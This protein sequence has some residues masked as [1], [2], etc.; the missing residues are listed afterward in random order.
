[1]ELFLDTGPS[2]PMGD[3][4]IARSLDTG[5][6]VSGGLRT[7]FFNPAETAA[8]NV[9]LGLNFMWN[10]GA[11]NE[12]QTRFPCVVNNADTGAVTTNFDPVSM[13]NLYRTFVNLGVGREWFLL[14]PTFTGNNNWIAGI[15]GGLRYGVARID[16]HVYDD[17]LFGGFVR[18]TD[19]LYG[20][21]VGLHTDLEI[22]HNC[23]TYLIGLR[24]EW[25]GM[26]LRS[27]L[28]Q[29]TINDQHLYDVNFLLTL[30]VR[31]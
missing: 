2:I 6:L 25:S 14:G 21:Y 9:D 22:P 20:A 26:Y 8:W 29:N 18:T 27:G 24:T 31:F 1:M 13:D 4:F 30:G 3:S 11:H 23:C 12:V 28:L 7:L 10:H 16:L 17:P 19:Q 15:D 5:W